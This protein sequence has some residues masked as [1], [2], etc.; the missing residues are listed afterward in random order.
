MHTTLYTVYITELETDRSSASINNHPLTF[1]LEACPPWI[2]P[3][4]PG[5]QKQ[6]IIPPVV[7]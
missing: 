3:K 1:R 5:Y 7:E 2:V 6:R 4:E